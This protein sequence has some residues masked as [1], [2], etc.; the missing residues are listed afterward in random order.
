MKLRFLIALLTA[1]TSALMGQSYV[2]KSV[3]IGDTAIRIPVPAKYVQLE[4]SMPL[5]AD[6]FKE[7]EHIIADESKNNTFILAAITPEK[8]SEAGKNGRLSGTLDCWAMYPNYSQ[9]TRIDIKQFSSFSS[10]IEALVKSPQ[11]SGTYA[12]LI[13]ANTRDIK[14]E[15]VRKRVESMQK[16]YIVSKSP[17]SI[18]IMSKINDEYILNASCLVNG[19]LIFLYIQRPNAFDSI[20]EICAWVKEIEKRTPAEFHGPNSFLA[21]VWQAAVPALL[22]AMGAA[23]VAAPLVFI[24]KFKKS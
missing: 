9:H 8:F 17:R 12:D 16:P 14:D 19:K 7:K 13:N 6:F 24:F 10:K 11:E 2:E 21:S 18:V 23:V 22:L 5:A 1:S 20:E 4:R 15:A 3:T